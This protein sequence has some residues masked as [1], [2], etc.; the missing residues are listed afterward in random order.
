MPNAWSEHEKL[1]LTPQGIGVHA[2]NLDLDVGPLLQTLKL[3]DSINFARRKGYAAPL[4][5]AELEMMNLTG[6]G[7]GFDMVSMPQAMRSQV[8]TSN[9]FQRRGYERNPVASRNNT[10]S[11][12]IA[13]TDVKMDKET[14]LQGARDLAA[15]F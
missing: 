8:P 1:G 6:D 2:L 7:N 15:A 4:S 3:T 11:K 14:A 12:L 13:A 5:A 9:F 10:V